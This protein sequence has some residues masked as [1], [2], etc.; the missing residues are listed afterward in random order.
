MVMDRRALVVLAL[1]GLVALSG[2]AL[3]T[4]ET[5]EFTAEKA[6]VGDQT[7]S[8]TGYEEVAV[9]EQTV[10]RSFSVAG[11]QREVR[12]TNWIASYQRGGSGSAPTPGT[13]TVLSTPEVSVAGQ[14]LNPIGQLSPRD[15]LDQVLRGYGDVSGVEQ[16]SSRTVTV[17]GQETNVT[18]FDAT[19]LVEGQ[20]VPVTI[21]L[22]T[23]NHEGD[24]VVAVGVH[25]QALSPEEAQVDTMFRGIEH[26]GGES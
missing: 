21:H 15:L 13:V 9:Q 17:L 10:N 4:G 19:I 11:E 1:A 5:L 22:T 24:Y 8:E 3:L 26:S 18:A 14:T 20:E 25:P 6:T 16:Q 7:L 23:V 12:L 2:C